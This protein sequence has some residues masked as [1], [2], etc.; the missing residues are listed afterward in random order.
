MG[1]WARAPLELARVKHSV[2]ADKE[3]RN[4]VATG[5]PVG[6]VKE[7][8]ASRPGGLGGA[9]GYGGGTVAVVVRDLPAK[10]GSGRRGGRGFSSSD[11]FERT[12]A[13]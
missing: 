5:F 11:P 12:P 1:A 13:P 7:A 3:L 4:G 2:I 9:D 8:F 6:S 10:V